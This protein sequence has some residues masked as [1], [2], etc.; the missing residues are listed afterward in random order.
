MYVKMNTLAAKTKNPWSNSSKQ[1]TVHIHSSS[2]GQDTGTTWGRFV[3]M[4]CMDQECCLYCL[5][6][7]NWQTVISQ[8]CRKASYSLYNVIANTAFGKKF[9][10]VISKLNRAFWDCFWPHSIQFFV[11]WLP[12]RSFNMPF[13]QGN[14]L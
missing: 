12:S 10:R 5:H 3:C 9:S 13:I 7:T 8:F 2:H 4:R 1:H 6:P 11:A 14:A